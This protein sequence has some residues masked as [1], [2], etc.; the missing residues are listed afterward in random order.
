MAKITFDNKVDTK[1]SK[2]PRKNSIVADDFNEIKA[3]VNSLYDDII[4]QSN[5]RKTNRKWVDGKD[6]YE[7]TLLIENSEITK[8]ITNN[9]KQ[10]NIS[11]L[12][13]DTIFIDTVH[14][15]LKIKPNSS[16]VY[17]YPIIS[18]GTNGSNVS[19][20]KTS[21]INILDYRNY[22][23]R[24]W[25]GDSIISNLSSAIDSKLYI[26]VEYTKVDEEE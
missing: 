24:M 4:F 1:Q 3:S 5:E 17:Q 25:I 6:I 10:I 15:I 11:S 7:N 20:I 14:S 12:K 21:S 8:A 19:N 23:I 22:S 9:V 13:I 16:I 18:V 2:K 26:T